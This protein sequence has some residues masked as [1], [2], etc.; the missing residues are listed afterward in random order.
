MFYYILAT[1]CYIYIIKKL[2]DFSHPYPLLLNLVNSALTPAR[3]QS[4]NQHTLNIQIED[5]IRDKDTG[6]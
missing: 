6:I 1:N 5:I 4:I 3:G 2:F